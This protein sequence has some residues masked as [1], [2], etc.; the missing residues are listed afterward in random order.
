MA[1]TMIGHPST[2]NVAISLLIPIS[3][4]FGGGLVP[5]GIGFSGEY[6]SFAFAII[7]FGI[8]MIIGGILSKLLELRRI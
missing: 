1:I 7:L 6:G 5:A 4:I 8:L 3:Y 2:R